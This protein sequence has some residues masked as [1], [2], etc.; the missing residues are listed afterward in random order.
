MKATR[1][2]IA[3]LALVLFATHANAQVTEKK[4]LTLEGARKVIAAAIADA[5]VKK[6][7]RLEL[8]DDLDE[9]L[10]IVPS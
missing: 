8:P 3:A 1:E 2:F 6:T 9:R 5:D 10:H 4:S 7:C